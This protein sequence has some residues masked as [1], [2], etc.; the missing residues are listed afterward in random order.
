[1][2]KWHSC[3]PCLNN[4]SDC[5]CLNYNP[6]LFAGHIALVSHGL[7]FQRLFS[8]LYRRTS[9]GGAKTP[10]SSSRSSSFVKSPRTPTL[11][12]PLIPPPPPPP[13]P[14][15]LDGDVS[16]RGRASNIPINTVN[17]QVTTTTLNLGQV[18]HLDINA[19]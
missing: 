1:M 8:S 5:S 15:R 4:S 19:V 10:G 7:S 9:E 13:P 14:P 6:I 16:M 18:T 3:L 17:I 12:A 11:G 2:L